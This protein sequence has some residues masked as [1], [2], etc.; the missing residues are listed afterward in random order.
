MTPQDPKTRAKELDPTGRA[1]GDAG[2]KLDAGK[3]RLGLMIHSFPRALEEVGKVTTFGAAK[4]SPG[5]WQHVPDGVARY[6][7]ALYRHLLAEARGEVVDPDSQLFH[8]AQ[9]AWNALA[10]LE[11]MLRQPALPGSQRYTEIH[12]DLPPE[13]VARIVNDSGI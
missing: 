10:R 8:A 9:S 3:T 1:S 11:L 13:E 4:Y 7:D 12:T 2:A 5:G 6:T